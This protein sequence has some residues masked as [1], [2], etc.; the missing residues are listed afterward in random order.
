MTTH[1][2]LEYLQS[3]KA[4]VF[5]VAELNILMWNTSKM[6]A[7][8]YEE[9]AIHIDK[10]YERVKKDESLRNESTSST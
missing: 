5:T 6:F 4:D 7:H 9:Y 10:I 8:E 3:L 2:K 1:E